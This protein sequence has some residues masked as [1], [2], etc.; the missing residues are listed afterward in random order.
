[1]S[2]PNHRKKLFEKKIK[3]LV[4]KRLKMQENLTDNALF[5]SNRSSLLRATTVPTFVCFL[6]LPCSLIGF[7]QYRGSLAAKKHLNNLN[8]GEPV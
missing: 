6:S 8:A 4:N 2:N 3:D 5:S 1:M 7:C